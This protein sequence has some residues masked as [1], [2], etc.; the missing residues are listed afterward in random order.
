ML[1]VLFGDCVAEPRLEK[2]TSFLSSTGRYQFTVIAWKKAPNLKRS[3]DKGWASIIRIA[4]PLTGNFYS[5]PFW[6]RFLVKSWLLLEF[7]V[8]AVLLGRKL[9]PDLIHVHDLHCLHIGVICRWITGNPLIY[10]SHE[11]F[12]LSVA[13]LS[14]LLGFFTAIF[15]RLLMPWADCVLTVDTNLE[16]R[17]KEKFKKKNVVVVRNFTESSFWS[18]P[19]VPLSERAREIRHEILRLKKQ[20]FFIVLSCST[21]CENIGLEELLQAKVLI[22]TKRPVAYLIIGSG[23]LMPKLISLIDRLSLSHVYLTGRLSREEALSFY[24]LCDVGADPKLPT[25]YNLTLLSSKIFE[26]V[27]AGLPVLAGNLPEA[28]IFLRQGCGIIVDCRDPNLIANAIEK[29]VNEEEYLAQLTEKALSISR[30]Y[31]WESQAHKLERLYNDIK[32]GG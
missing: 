1:V 19:P 23:P 12:P 11:N 9:R 32:L 3:E 5:F 27:S 16:R 31:T 22:K 13:E 14:P 26:Y 17:F 30:N 7:S 8:R 18:R 4:R 21:F 6:V 24:K 10:D 29:L 28:D 2:E 25:P 20:H 15:E